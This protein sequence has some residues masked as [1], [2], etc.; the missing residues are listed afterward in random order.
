MTTNGLFGFFDAPWIPVF[1]TVIFLFHPLLGYIALGGAAVLT[2]F[3]LV[4]E[5]RTRKP[6]MA[7]NEQSIQERQVL[8]AKLRN[9]E[10]IEALGMRPR[11]QERWARSSRAGDRLAGQGERRG[12]RAHLFEQ[13]FPP[14]APVFDPRRRRLAGH[15]TTGDPR[16][17]D[18]R[19]YSDGAGLGA[20]RSNDRCL[21]GIR[22]C[23]GKGAALK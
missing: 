3:A 13:G 12:G 7:A 23:A 22:E 18:R 2:V 10:V 16:G 4:N 21:E 1:L 15:S 20:H 14:T 6:L 19:L 17:H 9:V 5:W 11:I 8:D